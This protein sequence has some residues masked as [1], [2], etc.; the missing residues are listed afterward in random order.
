MSNYPK[1]LFGLTPSQIVE[2]LSL[3]KKYQGKVIYEWLVKGAKN[4]AEMTNLSKRD[5]SNLE[6]IYPSLFSSVIETEQVDE[7]GAIK[8]GLRLHDKKV[9]ECVL[10]T[11]NK[12]N[13]TACLSS[14][15][16]CAMG[17]AF[18]RT[19]TMGFIRNL[20]SFEIIEQFMHL[21]EYGDISHIVF[22][23][24]GEPLAN[25]DEVLKAI[26]YFHDPNG[27]GLSHRRITISTCGLIP[28]LEQLIKK[29]IPVKL[30]VS[31]VTANDEKRNNLMPI[32]KRYP[33]NQLKKTLIDFQK[34]S[35]R[36]FTF[37]CCLLSKINTTESDANK[38]ASYCRGLD[39]IINL[40]PYN[41][42][43]EL[44]W[45]TPSEDE[46]SNFEKLLI[47]KGV[48]LTRRVSRGR[49]INGACGQLAVKM[50]E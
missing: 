32:N 25:L 34:M 30:A 49:G 40:I 26:E 37:E 10:L 8:L 36:R 39:V 21:K 23:G 29:A 22:M 16:G 2:I 44:P 45:K 33:L 41:P 48:S 14:Q 28:G 50:D 24:M 3:E 17:C 5:R 42:G 4:F 13:R 6:E 20:E 46:I 43:A 35:G 12:G 19:G 27:I 38:L 7:T 1:S 11:D 15:V 18:C 31:L 9:V 47:S